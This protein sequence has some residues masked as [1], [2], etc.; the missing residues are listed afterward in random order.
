MNAISKLWHVSD[1]SAPVDLS[2]QIAYPDRFRI[3]YPSKGKKACTYDYMN[4][5]IGTQDMEYTLNAHLDSGSI[6][7]WEDTTYRECYRYIFEGKW[8]DYDAWSADQR[9][10]AQTDLYHRGGN[11]S[12][13]RSMQGWLSLSHCGTGEGTLR[14]LPSLKL[15]TA[16]LMLRPFFMDGADKFDDTQPTFPGA[17]PGG[18]QL[19]PTD[20]LHP[21][22]DLAKTMI[23]IP[24]VKP[25]DYVF[26]HCDLLHEV[27]K[28][29]PGKRDSSVVYNPCTPLI[30][31]NI[32][33]LR[34]TREAFLAAKPPRDFNGLGY[35][36]EEENAHADHGARKENILSEEGLRAMGFSRFD[37][38]EAGLSEGQKKVRQMANSILGL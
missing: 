37:D 20:E 3:R 30:P 5:L 24:P 6:E 10:D 34:A 33:S 18:T 12:C 2:T 15:S 23:G 19:L 1:S 31:Y 21:H 7:R 11:C 27:D 8:K 26:W 9:I 14:L 25:G 13:W 32:D 29:H 36:Y 16:Y 4:L 22:L 35:L 38:N 28:F 17:H